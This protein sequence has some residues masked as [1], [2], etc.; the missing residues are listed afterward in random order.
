MKK[1]SFLAAL[2]A[3]LL[4]G[5][6]PTPN[7]TATVAPRATPLGVKGPNGRVEA[8][9]A[10]WVVKDEDTTIYLFGTVHVL[11]PDVDWFDGAVKQ[12]YDASGDLV[13]E[14]VSPEA[15]TA[16]KY[17]MSKAIDPDGPALTAKLA[18]ADAAKYRAAM[19]A[20][21]LPVAAFET[22]EPWMV[23][24]QIGIAPLLKLG[25]DPESGA[26]Q[27]LSKAARVTSKPVSG[28]ETFEQQLGYFDNL[29]EPLQIRYLNLTV[30][31][32]PKLETQ[33]GEL[34]KSWA[35][36]D[37]DKLAALMNEGLR[38]MP[39]IGEILLTQR[40]ARWA[41]WVDDRLDRPGTTF[42]AVGAGHLAGSDSLQTMLT[43][44]GFTVTRLQ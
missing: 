31:E 32:L 26:E 42:V 9:P 11:R 34:T 36:G 15:Q 19:Q 20:N 1:L 27:V 25:Y 33:F 10:L 3:V 22:V 40:N 6:A 38:E 35:T 12:A 21:G 41:Q 2:T 29:P 7:E 17:V 18:P 37:A 28:L 23:A 14:M 24:T 8:D 39:E 13:L 16:Q 43:K 5:C 44:R 4:S 30:S